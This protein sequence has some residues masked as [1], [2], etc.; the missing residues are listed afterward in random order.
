[1]ERAMLHRHAK[2]LIA[3]SALFAACAALS[4]CKTQE[5]IRPIQKPDATGNLKH[6]E[7]PEDRARPFMQLGQRYMEMKKYDL[8][9]ENL[10]KAIKYDPRNADAR[11]VLATLYDRVGD[12]QAAEDNY[13]MA[14]EFA[15]RSGS[16]NNNYGLYLCKRGKF[17]L[18]RKYF[19]TALADGFYSD[20]AMVYTNAGTCQL[21]GKGSLDVAEGDFR[22]ALELSPN[23]PQAL[24]QLAEVLYQKSDFF[25]ARAFIQRYEGLAE[26]ANPEALLLARNIEIKLG[27]ADAARDYARR[28]HDQ[29]P[30]SEQTRSLDASPSS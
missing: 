26:Q 28:L 7:T 14:A 15:P 24:Y 2:G 16:A 4:S 19:D 13:R 30:D 17:D 18:S 5:G 25:K 1:M 27:N 22:H 23:S 12:P 3:A 11:T 9:R 6:D 20:K 8:A 29:F 21:L 10:L